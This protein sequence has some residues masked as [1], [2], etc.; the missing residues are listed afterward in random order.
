MPFHDWWLDGRVAVEGTSDHNEPSPEDAT[1]CLERAVTTWT[2]WPRARNRRAERSVSEDADADL[3]T[4]VGP[5]PGGIPS[6]D[7]LFAIARD[8]SL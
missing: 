8:L 2:R 1:Y 6:L 3:R 5:V 4:G 7:A